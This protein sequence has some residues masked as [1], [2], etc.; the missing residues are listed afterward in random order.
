MSTLKSKVQSSLGRKFITGLTGFGLFVFIIVHLGGNLLLLVGPDSFN[1]YAYYLHTAMQGWFVYIAEAG[2]MALFLFHVMEGL[3]V[4]MRKYR[5][6]PKRYE[7]VANAGGTSRKTLSSR[8]M[9]ISGIVILVFIVLHIMHFKFGPGAGQGYVTEVNGVE[10]RDLYRLVVEEFNKPAVVYAYVFVMLLLGMHLRHG[11]W[12]M[13]QSLGLA[14]PNTIPLL[15]AMGFLFAVVL[16]IGY[17]LI[18][19]YILYYVPPPSE[20]VLVPGAGV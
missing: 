3:T 5:A 17:I 10:M 19:L 16:A 2:L 12:S 11:F 7:M 18:P 1:A 14:R 6:R 9:A 13:F 20:A 8:T 4:Y 15:S